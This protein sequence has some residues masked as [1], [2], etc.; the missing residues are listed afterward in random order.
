M[1]IQ[2]AEIV[3]EPFRWAETRSIDAPSLGRDVLIE[4]GPISWAG[5]VIRAS[6]GF[7]LRGT[8]EYEQD[9]ACP[10]CLSPVR[11]PVASTVELAIEA[12]SN[13]P[14][15]GEIELDDD[16]LDVLYVDGEELDTEPIL[17]EQLQLN[18]PMRQL[19]RE[20]CRGLC[21]V[22]GQNL[23]EGDCDCDHD[24]IDPRWEALARLRG[25]D[26]ERRS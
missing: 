3:D 8:L 18:V 10:R 22:C 24:E 15:L 17:I 25:K 26:D 6:N 2:L 13:E 7:L 16:D 14:T 1:V 21:A 9:L 20:D 12:R 23:N 4:L 19:C 5:E 11:V